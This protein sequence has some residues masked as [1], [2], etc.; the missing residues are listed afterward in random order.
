[1]TG[2]QTCALPISLGDEEA[3][4]ILNKMVEEYALCAKSLL[5]ELPFAE[6]TVNIV[7]IGSLFTK[8]YSDIH[9]RV[10]DKIKIL[11]PEKEFVLHM[12]DRP[13]VAGA[14][15]WAFEEIGISKPWVKAM[16][17]FS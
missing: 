4:E 15:A 1:V 3:V 17:C 13:P 7:L 2:V 10:L 14:L 6:K 12:L 16:E 9:E 8:K 5:E 11:V